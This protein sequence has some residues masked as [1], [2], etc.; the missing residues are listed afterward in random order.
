[1]KMEKYMYTVQLS[2]YMEGVYSQ[3]AG[4]YDSTHYT[5][6]K[7]YLSC[8]SLQQGYSTAVMTKLQSCHKSI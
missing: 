7:L 4:M 8:A 3:H 5:V 1:M 6:H 2:Y